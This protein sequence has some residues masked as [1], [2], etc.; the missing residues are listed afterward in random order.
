MHSTSS[1]EGDVCVSC[2][3]SVDGEA[4]ECQW[5]AKWEHMK[6]AKMSKPEYDIL[7]NCTPQIVFFCSL[8]ISK[9]PSVLDQ[10]SN[11]NINSKIETLQTQVTD[12]VTKVN[13]QI[14]N[15]LQQLEEKLTSIPSTSQSISTSCSSTDESTE[16]LASQVIDEYRDRENRKLNVILHNVPESTS[17]DVTECI[18]HDTDAVLDLTNKI[19]A[20]PVEVSSVA[21]LGKKLDGKHRLMKVRFNT[22]QQKHRV[23]ANAKNLRSL[24]STL[25]KVFIT[26]DQSLKE[27]QQN[28]LLYDELLR[29]RRGGEG[30]L[31]IR[32]GKI[33]KRIQAAKPSSSG[34]DAMDTA[35]T[36]EQQA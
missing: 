23:L 3:E 31:V 22:M 33:T 18:S 4:V 10:T 21:R 20:G 7:S 11:V 14:N 5:C 36:S 19:G 35:R 8:C 29:H 15:R 16:N 32:R 12:L 2:N 27:R 17:T 34:G 26:P 30:D 1:Q 24:S 9:L 6:C 25:Q 28:K 13:E